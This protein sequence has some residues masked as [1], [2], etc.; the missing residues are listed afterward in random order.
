MTGE[1]ITWAS[2]TGAAHKVTSTY[3]SGGQL[4]LRTRC[5]SRVPSSI[6]RTAAATAH[7]CATCA[8]VNLPPGRGRPRPKTFDLTDTDEL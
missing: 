8:K 4:R 6:T 3:Q 1:W 5:G 7:K 2:P